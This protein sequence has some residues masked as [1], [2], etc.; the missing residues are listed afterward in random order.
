MMIEYLCKVSANTKSFLFVSLAN[1]HIVYVQTKWL[2]ERNLKPI[3]S[4]IFL[5]GGRENDQ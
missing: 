3:L 4:Q 1:L 2:P 5:K